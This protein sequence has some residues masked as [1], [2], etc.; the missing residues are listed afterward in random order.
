VLFA[1]IR[2]GNDGHAKSR[3]ETNTVEESSDGRPDREAKGIEQLAG[4][5]RAEAHRQPEADDREKQAELSQEIHPE[6]ERGLEPLCAHLPA[7]HLLEGPGRVLG[8]ENRPG[9]VADR[10]LLE[11]CIAVAAVTEHD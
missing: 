11:G 4:V 9:L 2:P 3:T 6:E 5:D 10:I 7:A 1:G 8:L